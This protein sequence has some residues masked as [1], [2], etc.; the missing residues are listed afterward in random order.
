[1]KKVL[2]REKISHRA[3][4]VEGFWGFADFAAMKNEEVGKLG[5][6]LLR[7]YSH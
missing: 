4:R 5:P 2:S 3:Y 6:L 7:D 1:M